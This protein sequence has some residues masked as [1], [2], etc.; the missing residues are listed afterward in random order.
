MVTTLVIGAILTLLAWIGL[1]VAV[2]HGKYVVD[3]I[4]AG[5]YEKGPLDRSNGGESRE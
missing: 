4:D 2:I 5:E 1:L 3:R